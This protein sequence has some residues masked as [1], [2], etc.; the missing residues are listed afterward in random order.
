[1]RAPGALGPGPARTTWQSWFTRFGMADTRSDAVPAAENQRKQNEVLAEMERALLAELDSTKFLQLLVESAS[2]RFDALTGVWLVVGDDVLVERITS[3]PGAFPEGRTAFGEGM[4]GRCAATRSG[5]LV[6]EYPRWEHA[7]SRYVAAGLRHAM[8]QPLLMGD[9]LLGVLTMMR[10]G[11]AASPFT[12]SDFASLERLAGLAAL[13]L[14]NSMLYE[15]AVRR[16][17]QVEVLAE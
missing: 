10:T 5:L 8:A 17:R 16:R 11:D 9:H 15:E 3:V 12:E 6:R 1:M 2:R 14:R 7:L 4:A 13:A